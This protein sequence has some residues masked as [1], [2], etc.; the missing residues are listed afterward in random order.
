MSREYVELGSVP[1]DEDCAQVGSD[2]YRERMRE[3]S[4]RYIAQLRRRFPDM[5]ESV[6]LGVKSFPHDFGTYHEVVAWF[7]TRDEVAISAA[8]AVENNLPSTWSDETVFS[9]PLVADNGEDE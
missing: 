1:C 6:T 8:Y 5:P 9:G 3:E 7:D 2:N 4:A